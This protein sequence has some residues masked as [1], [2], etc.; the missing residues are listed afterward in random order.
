MRR[1]FRPF[2]QVERHSAGM[3]LGLAIC[4]RLVHLMK[5]SI[6]VDSA[7][8]RRTFW[9]ELP[10]EIARPETLENKIPAS[11]SDAPVRGLNVLVVE[12]VPANQLAIRALMENLGHRVQVAVDG[13]D[14]IDLAKGKL[15]DLILMDIQMPVMNG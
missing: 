2:E 7:W 8:E 9:C 13:A 11:R 1:L 4:K 3:G 6:G 15:F 10:F 5:G 12:D 14:A